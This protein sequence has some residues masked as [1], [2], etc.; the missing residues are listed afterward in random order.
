MINVIVSTNV[1][2]AMPKATGNSTRKLTSA[3]AHR[4]ILKRKSNVIHAH[5]FME[6]TAQNATTKIVHPVKRHSPLM[7]KATP[8]SVQMT[9]KLKK[10]SVKTK[11]V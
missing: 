5:R 1:L 6:N 9:R 7:K 11:A 4:V 8:V 2:N 10:E 3:I